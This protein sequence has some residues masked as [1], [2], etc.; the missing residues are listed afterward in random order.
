MSKSNEFQ[1]SDA[2]QDR[3]KQTLD[4][5]LESAYAI[6]ESADPEAFNSRSLSKKSGYALGTLHKRLSSIKNV[7]LWAIQQGQKKHLETLSCITNEFNRDLPIQHL[8]EQMVDA[9]FIAIKKV[10]PKVIRFFETKFLQKN[11]LPPNFFGYIDALIEPYIEAAL[12][13]R[14]NTFRRMNHD[15]LRLTLRA[16][17]MILERPF[18]D[19]DPIAGTS[20]HRQIAIEAVVRLLG[21]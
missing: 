7:F 15:E 8:A 14:T 11:G 4:D 9:T 18:V 17:L 21:R 10:N 20:A 19:L 6:V 16:I 3:S 1:F 12:R 2:K 13:D 5:L